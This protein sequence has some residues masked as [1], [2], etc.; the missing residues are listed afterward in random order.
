[1]FARIFQWTT[2]DPPLWYLQLIAVLQV[3]ESERVV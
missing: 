2:T 3:N 1:M